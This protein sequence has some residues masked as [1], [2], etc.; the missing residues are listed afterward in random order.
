MA[1]SKFGK[2]NIRKI[3][4]SGT[5]L[6]ISI[7]VEFLKRLGWKER[8]RVVVKLEGRKLVIKDWRK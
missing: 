2:R 8:Q 4:R 6:N 7:P 5:S 3:T 1:N